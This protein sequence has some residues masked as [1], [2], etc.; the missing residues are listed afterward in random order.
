MLELL[1]RKEGQKGNFK[2]LFFFENMIILR[3]IH[4]PSKPAYDEDLREILIES[5]KESGVEHQT[6]GTAV[7]IEGPRFSSFAESCI[8]RDVYKAEIV[9][10]TACPESKQLRNIN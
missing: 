3:I 10:M 9:N 4:L 2:Q 6:R 5:L 8:F 7:C 1:S